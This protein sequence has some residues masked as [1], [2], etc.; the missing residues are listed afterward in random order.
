MPVLEE[1][2][3]F[4]E[5]LE[6]YSPEGS[7]IGIGD[8]RLSIDIEADADWPVSDSP[9]GAWR[10]DDVQYRNGKSVHAG[11]YGYALAEIVKLSVRRPEN[12]R[13]LREIEE[14]VLEAE[15]SH[16]PTYAAREYLIRRAG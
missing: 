1:V 3:C 8:F 16:R 7:Y 12:K 14:L 10:I 4:A 6:L 5:D 11:Q 13:I 2:H 15:A 9:F